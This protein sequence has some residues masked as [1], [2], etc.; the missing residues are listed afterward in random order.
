M[1]RGSSASGT[2][3]MKRPI[4]RRRGFDEVFIHGEGGIGQSYPGSCGDAPGNTYFNPAILHNGTFEKTQGFCTDVF[5]AQATRWI[6]QQH[7]GP[8]PFFAYITPNAPHGPFVCPEKFSK[9]YLEVGMKPGEAAYYGMITNIDEN[10]GRLMKALDNW[11]LDNQTLLIFMTDNGH[12][13]RGLYNAGM[14]GNKGTAYEGG[15]HVPAFWRWKG[16][17]PA[18]VD[19]KA[20]HRAYRSVSDLRRTGRCRDPGRDPARRS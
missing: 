11:K 1:P 2:W 12:P 3:G 20:N 9:P 18:G 4:S 17:L 14:H 16:V 5:F 7:P 15:T 6:D 10:M 13:M 8:G 19:C